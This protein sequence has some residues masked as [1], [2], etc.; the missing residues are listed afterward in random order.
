MVC[1]V[2]GYPKFIDIVSD[3]TKQLT[4]KEQYLLSFSHIKEK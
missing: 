4:F 2:M 1:G 3:F